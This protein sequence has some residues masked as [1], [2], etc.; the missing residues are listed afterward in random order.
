LSGEDLDVYA[1]LA[2]GNDH[3]VTEWGEL[4]ERLSKGIIPIVRYGSS[5]RD[6]ERLYR[7]IQD[8]SP[9]IPVATD[10]IHALHILREGHLDRAVRRAIELGVDPV[11]AIASVT[12]APALLYGMH[13]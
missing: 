5:W 6:L 1:S 11:K 8:Y 9:L 7:A 12:L 4:I 3:E 10:D 2:I 13:R